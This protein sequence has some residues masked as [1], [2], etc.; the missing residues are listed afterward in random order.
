MP[1]FPFALEIDS[2]STRIGLGRLGHTADV[3][4]LTSFIYKQKKYR[5][6]GGGSDS[7]EVNLCQKRKR[8]RKSK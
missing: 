6:I 8:K 4:R 7:W 2:L 3:Y 5:V 1:T